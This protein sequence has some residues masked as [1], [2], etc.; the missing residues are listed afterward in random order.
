MSWHKGF[1]NADELR[2]ARKQVGW[3]QRELA[4]RAQVNVRTVKYHEAKRH[5]RIDGVAPG[6]F[7]AQLE[8]AGAS[9]QP[10]P[11]RRMP[12]PTAFEMAM[13]ARPAKVIVVPDV[14]APPKAPPQ[15]CGA[16]TRSGE[17][18]K[19]KAMPGKRRCKNHG[20][21]STGPKTPEGRARIAAAARQRHVEPVHA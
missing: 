5:G 1:I 19:A 10:L 16:K 17:P 20:G 9:L 11:P 21:M 3:T 8:A 4:R 12:P 6:W 13:L 15:L 7:R 18:C 2:A 14:P